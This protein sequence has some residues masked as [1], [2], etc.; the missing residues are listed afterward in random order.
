MSEPRDAAKDE[1]QATV[2]RAKLLFRTAAPHIRQRETMRLLGWLVC[3]VDLK[4]AECQRL[5]EENERLRLELIQ[6][7]CNPD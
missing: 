3:A 4:T 7:T 1:I 2:D 6:W 5:K